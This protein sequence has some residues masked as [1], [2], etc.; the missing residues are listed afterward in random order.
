M[1]NLIKSWN[2]KAIR[3]R[4]D[5]Y[6][7]L[8]DMAQASGKL[9]AD[10][11]RLNSTKS[12][13]ET[14]SRSMQIPI[15]VLIQVKTT[16]RNEDRGTWGHPKVSIRFAQWCNDEFAVWVDTQ[17]DELITTGSVTIAAPEPKKA[18]AYYSDRCADIRKNLVK[19]KGHWC[20]IE[21]C[22]H[23]LLEVEKAGYPIDK[24]DL[25]DSSVG[26]KW[27]NYRREIGLTEIAQLA[28]YQLPH[29][30]LPVAIACYPSSELGIFSDWLEGI[31]EEKYLNK[32][33]QDKY[34]KLAKV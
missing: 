15:D 28:H 16:G 9:F 32:Y 31:Y 26:K 4:S 30:P 29:C 5:R 12:Y 19:P 7:S 14:L 1:T 24:Y 8:T 17:I 27:A 11:N 10:W 18:I 20:V 22:N 3:I 13:L 23:L 21:K 6:V 25:L 33:L 34:G 2:N